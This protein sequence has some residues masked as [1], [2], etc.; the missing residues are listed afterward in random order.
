[1]GLNQDTEYL[2]VNWE[3]KYMYNVWVSQSEQYAAWI[4]KVPGTCDIIHPYI[5]KRVVWRTSTPQHIHQKLSAQYF[6]DSLMSRC[7]NG[8]RIVVKLPGSLSGRLPRTGGRGGFLPN[9]PA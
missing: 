2:L 8:A 7:G 5:R 1:M 6:D 9:S 3:S 4:L